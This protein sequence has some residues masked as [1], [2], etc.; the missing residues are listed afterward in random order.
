V[1]TRPPRGDL[2]HQHEAA[3]PS[4]TKR[5]GDGVWR[6][7]RRARPA[8]GRPRITCSPATRCSVGSRSSRRPRAR[9]AE[10]QFSEPMKE[11]ELDEAVGGVAGCT[12]HLRY[13]FRAQLLDDQQLN[14]ARAA[15]AALPRRRAPHAAQLVRDRVRA[16]LRRRGHRGHAHRHRGGAAH[17]AAQSRAWPRP[18]RASPRATWTRASTCPAPTSSPI[19]ARRSNRMLADLRRSRTE[20]EYLQKIGAWQ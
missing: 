19:S 11:L 2:A 16:A 18:P 15:R 1:A 20:I 12:L 4:G 5:D 3:T 7:R 9:V 10:R 14:R 17:L 8:A 13:G 6:A